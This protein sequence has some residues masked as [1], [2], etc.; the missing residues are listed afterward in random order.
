MTKFIEY[1][2]QHI[3]GLLD[4]AKLGFVIVSVE[5]IIEECNMHFA[6]WLGYSTGELVGKHVASIS[7]PDDSMTGMREL[8][9]VKRGERKYV[10]QFKK[11]VT[12]SGKTKTGELISFPVRDAGQ[13]KH[14][15]SVVDSEGN[16]NH[17]I[18][19]LKAQVETIQSVLEAVMGKEQKT[20]IQIGGNQQHVGGRNNTTSSGGESEVKFWLI[21]GAV[22]SGLII[23]AMF[24]GLLA[25][26]PY[27]QGEAEVPNIPTPTIESEQ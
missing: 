22:L 4:F 20:N 18:D 27:H 5:G 24:I 6:E 3:T 10:S 2:E 13:I 25:A 1:A 19:E 9:A 7:H 23:A 12:K 8:E 17:E 26:W 11:Y 14:F 21:A 15:F 16:G